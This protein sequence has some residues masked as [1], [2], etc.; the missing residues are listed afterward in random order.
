[1]K[2][3]IQ[4]FIDVSFI[5]IASVHKT[6]SMTSRKE[7]EYITMSMLKQVVDTQ[8]KAF[9]SAIKITDQRCQIRS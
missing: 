9:K 1:M 6:L 5:I 7:P 3:N 8:E 2:F 4:L